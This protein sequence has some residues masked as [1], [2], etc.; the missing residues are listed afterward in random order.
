MNLAFLVAGILFQP[1]GAY[2]HEVVF[3]YIILH[4]TQKKSLERVDSPIRS[5]TSIAETLEVTQ[6][7]KLSLVSII[8][9]L[10]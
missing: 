1:F 10:M 9:L 5:R 2:V 8:V 4:K 6:L 3:A 7:T